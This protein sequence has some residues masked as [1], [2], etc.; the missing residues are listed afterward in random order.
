MN[1]IYI[2]KIDPSVFL[3]FASIFSRDIEG[4]DT[5]TRR[6]V[7]SDLIKT[8]RQQFD[9]KVGSLREC[10]WQLLLAVELCY[11]LRRCLVCASNN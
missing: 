8:L 5:D 7:A 11:L 4:S 6:R 1:L 2:R 10:P 9:G 3:V